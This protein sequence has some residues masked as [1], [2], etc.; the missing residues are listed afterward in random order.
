MPSRSGACVTTTNQVRTKTRLHAL[1]EHAHASEGMAPNPQAMPPRLR[2][3]NDHYNYDPE[4]TEKDFRRIWDRYAWGQPNTRGG[5]KSCPDKAG[6][7]TISCR[8]YT[9]KDLL[10]KNKWGGR[11]IVNS[12]RCCPCCR[13]T[14][15]GPRRLWN[16]RPG[17]GIGD[18]HVPG[19]R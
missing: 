7:R 6:N 15:S 12:I 2:Q 11:E 13:E 8:H 16:C 14:K 1:G 9:I 4:Y 19:I 10:N 3:Y 18:K 17:N 5:D